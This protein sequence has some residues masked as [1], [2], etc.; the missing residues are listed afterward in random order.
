ML[1]DEMTAYV[2]R[3]DEFYPPNTVDLT[4]VE[5][6]AVYDRMC[7]AFHRPYPAA[8]KASDGRIAGPAGD[9]PV[10]RYRRRGG[11]GKPLLLYFH[12]G[13]FVVG[14]LESHDGVCAELCAGSGLEVLAVD[15][16]LAP[17]HRH[18]AH[19]QDALAAFRAIAG[20]GR[21][22]IVA[23]D[24]AGGNLAAA[25]AL[26]TRGERLKPIGQLLI[27]PGL[28]G[29]DLGLASYKE[30]AEAI[31]LTARDVAYY[32]RARAGEANVAGDWTFAPLWAKSFADLPA[33]IAIS[34]DIDPLRDDAAEYVRRVCAAGGEAQWR[35][36]PG[37]V[38]G[39]LRARIMSGR[40]KASFDRICAYAAR[41]ASQGPL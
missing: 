31:H 13:G 30:H 2:A 36:E 16:R 24:S 19:Y 18:P 11:A 5:Q 35:N 28:G 39:Y 7:E 8:V 23:G 15:Y 21:P 10:R 38:H 6:R 41:L 4:L 32:R 17:E 1:D 26:A 9:V 14:G 20:E 33:C 3:V 34:A 40:A 29:E 25:I 22:V 27:Y 12:G 37:L